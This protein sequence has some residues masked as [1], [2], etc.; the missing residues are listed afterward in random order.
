MKLKENIFTL[1]SENV[2]GVIGFEPTASSSRT[3]RATGLRYTPKND[4]QIYS[5]EWL[6]SFCKDG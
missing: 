1:M 4:S 3:K 2:V 6:M 5:I